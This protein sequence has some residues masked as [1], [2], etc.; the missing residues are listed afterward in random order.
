MVIAPARGKEELM[1]RVVVLSIVG[2]AVAATSAAQVGAQTPSPDEKSYAELVA[3]NYVVL[4]RVKS[5]RLVRFATAFSGC[6]AKHGVR[7]GAPRPTKTKITMAIPRGTDRPR[8]NRVGLSCGNA[9][10]NPP[11]GA[12]L[13]TMQRFGDTQAV[14]LYVPRQCLL[15][16]EVAGS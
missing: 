3:A 12:S 8:L 15:D 9:L 7:V 11:R 5:E 2:V 6:L 4:S 10:G 16:P 14:V 1:P 13:Q